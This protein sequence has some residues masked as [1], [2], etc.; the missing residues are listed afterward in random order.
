MKARI[1]VIGY[2]WRADFYCRIA[3]ILPERFEI[4][5]RVLRTQER[6]AEVAEKEN[7]F[8]TCELE[9]ALELKPDYAV[10]CI[11]R[12]QAKDYL[13]RLMEAGVPV[14]CETPPGKDTQELEELW[15]ASQRLHGRVQVAEQYFLQPYYAAVQSVIDAGFLGEVN[16]VMLSAVHGY[17]A[18]SIYR[19]FLGLDCENCVIRGQKLFSP[20]TVTN[21]RGGFDYSGSVTQADRD[22]AALCFENGKTAFLDFS[23]EQYFSPIRV[24]RWN[25]RGVRGEVNDDTVCFLNEGNQAVRQQLER[26]DIGINNNSE[27]SHRGI[28]FLD[29]IVYENPFYPARMNDDETAV[30]SCMEKMMEYVQTGRE[31]YPLRDGLQDAYL[32]FEMERALASGEPVQ[33]GTRIW[34]R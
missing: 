8:A 12:E 34:G 4:C 16:E 13:I 1:V 33:T 23:G 21:G 5:A 15:Q 14:L 30:A 31:F 26:L 10:L 29:R 18:V 7:V 2:G 9:R 3:K 27:W 17:H 28:M 20:V 25:I 22:W 11:P 6:A 24:R 32:S 19:K